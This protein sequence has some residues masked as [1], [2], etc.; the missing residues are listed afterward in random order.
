M[1]QLWSIVA[2]RQSLVSST[3]AD[4]ESDRP[5]VVEEM[6]ASSVQFFPIG[7]DGVCQSRSG[8]VAWAP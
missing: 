5:D 8:T 2:A 3:V 7:A 6:L 1:A 4:L